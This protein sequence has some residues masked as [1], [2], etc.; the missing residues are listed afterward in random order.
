[1]PAV[2]RRRIIAGSFS[3]LKF[4]G[5]APAG[6]VLLRVFLGGAMQREMMALDDAEMAAAARAEIADLL[7]IVADPILTRVARWAD[8]MPQYAVGHLDSGR[9]KSKSASGRSVVFCWRALHTAASASP[10]ASTAASRRPKR[11]GLTCNQRRA[12]APPDTAMNS[13]GPVSGAENPG[14]APWPA[15]I[16]HADMDAFYAS[17]EQLDRPELRG[18]AL[19]VGGS[20]RRGVVTSAS[21]EARAFGVRAAMPTAQAHKLCPHGIFVPGRMKRY[22]EISRQ[23]RA[24]FES[25]TPI[26]EP[27]SLDEAFLDLGG[28]QRLFGSPIQAGWALKREVKLK[29][30]LVISV[31]IAPIKMVAKIL[32]DMSKPDG[33]LVL[34]PGLCRPISRA[35]AGANACG[36]LG[37]SRWSASTPRASGRSATWRGPTPPRWPAASDRSEPIWRELAHGRDPRSVVGD[38]QRKSY[39]EENTFEGDLELDAAALRNALIAHGE[40]LARRLRADQVKARTITLKLK[41]ARPLGG[42]RYPL[43]TRSFSLKGA[44]DDGAEITRVAI[45]LLSH[46]QRGEKIRLAGVQVHNLE[47]AA[48]AQLGLFGPERAAASKHARLNLALDKVT[49]RFGEEAI[50]RGF[51]RAEKAA[52]STRIK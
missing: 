5:R 27:L 2:E 49:R 44:T 17:V 36:A 41:L 7:G 48:T 4:A 1:M 24:V 34:G 28:T 47:R 33:L 39:G 10:T 22:V 12:R 37:G 9:R 16:A 35:A 14:G 23:I 51:A 6:C 31:G 13:G 20:S 3:S 30:G 45:S 50:S 26:V 46:V 52:P 42:G 43:I 11:H 18:K 21:Y 25:F 32:S 19:I 38:W 40:A 29:T 15:I 8:S